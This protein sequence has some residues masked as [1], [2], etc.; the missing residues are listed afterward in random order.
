MDGFVKDVTVDVC[1]PLASVAPSI[2]TY[3]P[4]IEKLPPLGSAMVGSGFVS[5]F[6]S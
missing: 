6:F 1:A 3:P 4:T 2:A 5:P